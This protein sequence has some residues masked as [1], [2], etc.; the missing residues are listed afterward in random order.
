[1]DP[2]RVFLGQ[3]QGIVKKCSEGPCFNSQPK[4]RIRRTGKKL[5]W[6]RPSGHFFL[7]FRVGTLKP[8]FRTHPCGRIFLKMSET[9]R[10]GINEGSLMRSLLMYIEWGSNEGSLILG[11]MRTS[12]FPIFLGKSD[13]TDES[14]T[15]FLGRARGIVKKNAPNNLV[16]T[17]N[18][19]T[20]SDAREK[21]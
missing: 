17:V 2:E 5:A 20:V 9:P 19:K 3:T 4:N 11:K 7:R 13:R 12:L 14:R 15:C 10:N 1:M 21:N 16:L 18:Q 6:P 8:T